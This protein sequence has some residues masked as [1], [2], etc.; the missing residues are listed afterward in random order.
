MGNPVPHPE[1]RDALISLYTGGANGAVF[2]QKGPNDIHG[3]NGYFH[4]RKLI[5]RGPVKKE[6]VNRIPD[7][8]P[9][10]HE[11]ETSGDPAPIVHDIAK[12]EGDA[13]RCDD[14]FDLKQFKIATLLKFPEFKIVWR[15]VS[16]EIGC[17][18]VVL[19]L[20]FLQI[21]ISDLDLDAYTRYPR[22]LGSL[23]EQAI[24]DCIWRAAL[25]GA[26]IGVALGNF[27]AAIAAPWTPPQPEASC[28]F[29]SWE[30]WRS[31]SAA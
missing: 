7:K 20:P 24:I 10:P 3:E 23:V 15:N 12:S 18:R 30:H 25:A 6:N 5:A 31:S 1:A 9:D 19:T 29:T 21:R 4:R 16:I 2:D 28:C 11:I 14:A 13:L 26:V 22:N 17:I 8:K 27:G